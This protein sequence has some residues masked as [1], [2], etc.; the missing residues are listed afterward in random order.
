M[1]LEKFI[2]DRITKAIAEGE[3]D[4]LP[5][6]GKPLDLD[7]YFRTPED[8][9]LGYSILRSNDCL[10]Q[11][12]AALKEIDEL[13]K[14]LGDC[15]DEGERKKLAKAIN[16]KTLSFRLEIERRKLSR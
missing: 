4:N 3:F 11:E 8:L 10:P 14:R 13:K 2:E 1:S 12:A 16:E 9:R 15:S 6:K 5:G 7:W